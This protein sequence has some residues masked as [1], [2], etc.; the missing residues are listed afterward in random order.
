[1]TPE[2]AQALE[3]S[4][5]H[6]EQNVRATR[7]AQA[8]ARGEDCALCQLYANADK[9]TGDCGQGCP[10]A[11]AGHNVCQGTPYREAAITLMTWR[12]ARGPAYVIQTAR[13]AFH[14]AARAE[15]E[16]LKSLRDPA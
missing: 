2:A 13:D 9:R 6:W 15:V 14:A 1:M 3:R 12:T 10:V 16:F 5:Q 4:I 11:S 7:P 8:S